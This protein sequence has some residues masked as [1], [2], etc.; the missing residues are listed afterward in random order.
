[1]NYLEPSTPKNGSCTGRYRLDT[2]QTD[3]S[4]I[5]SHKVYY[6]ISTISAPHDCRHTFNMLLDNAGVDRVARYKL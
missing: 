5:P 6:T 2:I 4:I 1:M 3:A